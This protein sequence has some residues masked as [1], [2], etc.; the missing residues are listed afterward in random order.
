MGIINMKYC[1]E[2]KLQQESFLQ[3]V[4]RIVAQIAPGQVLTYGQVALLAGKPHGARQVGR[5]MAR[6]PGELSLPCH[7]VVRADGVL[8][9][10]EVFGSQCLQRDLLMQEGVAFTA[11][12]R[13]DFAHRRGRD[14]NN[15]G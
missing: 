12:G 15:D 14:A 4:Y 10:D 1:L 5:L 9:P 11:S 7:R 2:D 6:V 13:I 3:A 8:A